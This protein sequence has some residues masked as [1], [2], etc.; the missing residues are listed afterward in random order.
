MQQKLIKSSDISSTH[1]T[2][3]LREWTMLLLLSLVW[4]G[5]FFFVGVAI[6]ELQAISIVAFRVSLAAVVLVA[7]VHL[8]G[9]RLPADPG[10]WL[11]FLMMGI[12]NNILPFSL[13]AWGQQYI[14]SSLAAVL[15]AATPVFGVVFAHLL[16]Q[17]EKLTGK[18][19]AGVIC[20]WC[21]VAVIMG[22]DTLAGNR[23]Q[24]FGQ[25]S[26]LSA[27]VLYALAAIYGKRFKALSPLVVSAGMLLSSS[28]VMV[29]LAIFKE[30]ATF[31]LPS[32]PTLSALT[33]LA[34]ISTAFAYILYFRILA[35]AGATNILLVT[36]LIPV[37]AT[38][39]GVAFLGESLTRVDLIGMAGIALGLMLIDGRLLKKRAKPFV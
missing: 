15:N 6:K 38:V 18:R 8:K 4:G 2:M 22:V 3:N 11:G 25:L 24:V 21:G 10:I 34:V 37:S 19:A 1:I 32:L 26:V 17:T 9:A 27:G 20:S 30:P 35:T 16:T 14:E 7:V 28:V 31:S 33:G 36:F 23:L 39:L 5:S 12:L 29:P 13:I